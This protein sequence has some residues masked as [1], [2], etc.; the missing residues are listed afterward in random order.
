MLTIKSLHISGAGG[1]MFHQPWGSGPTGGLTT[2]PSI[3]THKFRNI[4]NY[5]KSQIPN[6][7]SQTKSKILEKF[8]NRK[9]LLFFPRSWSHEKRRH[10]YLRGKKCVLRLGFEV[11]RFVWDLEFGI[12]EIAVTLKNR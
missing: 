4:V 3:L 5:S 9:T 2:P 12:F 1:D 7:K 10:R 8:K 6:S 11:L